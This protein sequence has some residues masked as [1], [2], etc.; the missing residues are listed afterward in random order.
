MPVAGSVS[1]SASCVSL[2]MRSRP[3]RRVDRGGPRARRA[4]RHPQITRTP[5][6]ALRD[7]CGVVT[8]LRGL[9]RAM[10]ATG[11][12]CTQRRRS[13]SESA[14]GATE[15]RDR[16]DASI[17]PD[18]ARLESARTPASAR[19]EPSF[20]SARTSATLPPRIRLRAA[21]L[22]ASARQPCTLHLCTRPCTHYG[23]TIFNPVGAGGA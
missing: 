18:L 23:F 1:Q 10:S 22:I 5:L 15:R 2:V 21:T 8:T 7:R 9:L 16:D 13:Q 20:D 17:H 11:T 14:P 6:R 3:R 19:R 4:R 12:L